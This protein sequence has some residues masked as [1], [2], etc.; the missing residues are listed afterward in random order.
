M[1]APFTVTQLE[2]AINSVVGSQTSP[3]SITQTTLAQ[4]LKDIVDSKYNKADG[5]A[6]D[7]MTIPVCFTGVVNNGD[8]LQDILS[9]LMNAVCNISPDTNI[10][11]TAFRA[12]KT[13]TQPVTGAGNWPIYFE[14]DANTPNFD[15]GNRFYVDRYIANGTIAKDFI[16]EK[17]RFTAS[18][19]AN[20]VDSVRIRILKNGTEIATTATVSSSSTKDVYGNTVTLGGYVFPPLIAEDVSLIADDIVTVELVKVSGNTGTIEIDSVF[21][22]S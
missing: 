5:I 7:G 3:D 9:A 6:V 20:G 10:D 19:W 21:S 11:M 12:T 2:A 1:P 4:L 17:Q 16:I 13:A 18:G 22:N 8:P 14:D 15:N